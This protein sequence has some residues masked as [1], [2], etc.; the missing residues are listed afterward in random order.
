MKLRT[1]HDETHLMCANPAPFALALHISTGISG[2]MPAPSLKKIAKKKATGSPAVWLCVHNAI[3]K[4]RHNARKRH[5]REVRHIAAT[6]NDPTKSTRGRSLAKTAS[7][8]AV[9]SVAVWH[10]VRNAIKAVKKKRHFNDYCK[11]RRLSDKHFAAMMRCRA[12]LTDAM[13]TQ[14]TIKAANTSALLGCTNQELVEHLGEDMWDKRHDLDLVIDHIWPCDA[15]DLEKA[16]QQRM[17]F[18]FRNLRLCTRSE[19]AGKGADLPEASLAD[20]VPKNL[21]P[22]Q[23]R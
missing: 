16:S 9:G 14:G 4:V 8:R 13:K 22:P 10:C 18:N 15:Y 3:T 5:S 6:K 1:P 2:R 23:F 17:C 20:T 7:E 19:N 12:R 21:W 11:E